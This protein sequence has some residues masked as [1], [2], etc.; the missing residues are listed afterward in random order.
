VDP[1]A[2]AQ[3]AASSSSASA[4]GPAV[5]VALAIIV[6][7]RYSVPSGKDAKGTIPGRLLAVVLVM[8]VSWMLLAA[9]HPAAAMTLAGGTASGIATLFGAAAKIL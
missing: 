9:Y 6:I 5:L 4:V 7:W 2:A 8:A 3:A 1:I